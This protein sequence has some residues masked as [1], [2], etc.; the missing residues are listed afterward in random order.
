MPVDV[1]NKTRKAGVSPSRSR[2]KARDGEAESTQSRLGEGTAQTRL[3]FALLGGGGRRV[4]QDHRLSAQRQQRGIAHGRRLSVRPAASPANGRQ[5]GA[6]APSAAVRLDVPGNFIPFGQLAAASTCPGNPM[7]R[8]LGRWARLIAYRTAAGADD[9]PSLSPPVF[10]RPGFSTEPFAERTGHRRLYSGRGG[11]CRNCSCPTGVLL[12]AGRP[13]P[14]RW[15]T[16][17]V[18]HFLIEAQSQGYRVNPV[19]MTPADA[20]DQGRGG[21]PWEEIQ[22]MAEGQS[23]QVEGEAEAKANTGRGWRGI[24]AAPRHCR[25]PTRRRHGEATWTGVDRKIKANWCWTLP[26][27][28]QS[29]VGPAS[30]GIHDRGGL[31]Q[32]DQLDEVSRALL[33]PGLQPAGRPGDGAE[34]VDANF[35]ADGCTVNSL[36]I[37]TRRSATPRCISRPGR[38]RS[39][40]VSVTQIVDFLGGQMKKAISV[41]PGER[42]GP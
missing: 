41:P 37:S 14:R 15:L 24:A 39:G 10:E 6:L 2:P 11:S 1:F 8:Y 36:A 38:S 20:V 16:Y 19:V 42:L 17:Y 40:V 26:A 7:F 35:K 32:A 18:S 13:A 30:S 9:K 12:L 29:V 27:L 22:K 34:T 33:S 4:R 3:A 28:S 31:T 25:S 23:L 21:I 5:A